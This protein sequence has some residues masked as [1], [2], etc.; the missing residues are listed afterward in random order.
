MREN[1]WHM[2]RRAKRAGWVGQGIPVTAFRA[3]ISCQQ[4][5]TENIAWFVSYAFYIQVHLSK[6][7]RMLAHFC[8][9]HYSLEQS[10]QTFITVQILPSYLYPY[11]LHVV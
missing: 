4:N 7:F 8:C 6:I 11:F 3:S 2:K 10:T 9:E 5:G 1:M